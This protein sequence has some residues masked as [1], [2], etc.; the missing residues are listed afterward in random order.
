MIAIAPASATDASTPAAPMVARCGAPRSC[1][2][3][4]DSQTTRGA[5]G[6]RAN[7]TCASLGRICTLPTSSRAIAA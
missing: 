7:S 5:A 4:S 1:S 2:I 3:A 6:K